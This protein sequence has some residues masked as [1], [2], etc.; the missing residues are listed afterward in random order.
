RKAFIARPRFVDVALVGDR[1]ITHSLERHA[2]G[3]RQPGIAFEERST[4]KS[5]PRCAPI[6]DGASL[7]AMMLQRFAGPIAIIAAILLLIHAML[8]FTKMRWVTGLAE[9]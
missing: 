1:R 8:A 9:V 3:E 4:S 5:I 7:E 6:I 2:V